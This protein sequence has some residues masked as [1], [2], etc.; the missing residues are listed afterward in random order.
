MQGYPWKITSSNAGQSAN[1]E[2]V[3]LGN[4]DF[5]DLRA[6][7]GIGGQNSPTPAEKVFPNHA[8]VHAGTS[9]K[10][11]FDP[12][13]GVRYANEADMETVSVYG[14]FGHVSYPPGA[15]QVLVR[16]KAGAGLLFQ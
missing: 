2:M 7:T 16:D 10:P 9:A 12:S 11:Y 4:G 8:I 1:F 3:P 13:Y 5:G 15:T 6:I 14:F